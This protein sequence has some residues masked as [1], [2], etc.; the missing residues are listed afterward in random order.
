MVDHFFSPEATRGGGEGGSLFKMDLW[1]SVSP[2]TLTFLPLGRQRE[3]RICRPP[4]EL[5][6]GAEW[7]DGGERT[8]TIS[9]EI[10]PTAETNLH[11][12]SLRVTLLK[13]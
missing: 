2:H 4:S 3:I 12:G 9:K 13:Q 6:V 8:N 11:L 5:G 10:S 7:G 1:F